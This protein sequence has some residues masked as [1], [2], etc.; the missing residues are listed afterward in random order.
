MSDP[1]SQSYLR[2]RF[3][4]NEKTGELI[5][6]PRDKKHFSKN[7]FFLQWNTR[8]AGKAAGV[9]AKRR[10]GEYFGVI[11]NLKIGNHKKFMYA[12]R[13]VWI[14]Q[15]GE[16]PEGLVIDHKNGNPCD[17]RLENLRTVTRAQ[18]SLNT[19]GCRGRDLP[20]G[21]YRHKRK[22]QAK[23]RKFHAGTFNTVE[24]ARLAFIEH[25]NKIFG[26]FSRYY[27]HGG[28]GKQTNET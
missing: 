3:S 25:S 2:E 26:E 1:A 22:F 14:L 18:N 20:H 13:I 16:I 7:R 15:V 9:A 4:Y 5:W 19:G 8:Y 12:H 10:D 11:V 28:E 17:N 21:V 6:K 23:C 24:E 27:P